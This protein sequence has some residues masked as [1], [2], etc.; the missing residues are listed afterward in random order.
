MTSHPLWCE[1]VIGNL[2]WVENYYEWHF[3]I[4]ALSNLHDTEH[5]ISNNRR[6]VEGER[7]GER[8]SSKKKKR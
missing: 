1:S 3:Y 6:R 8:A 7:N 2:V 5:E 4:I